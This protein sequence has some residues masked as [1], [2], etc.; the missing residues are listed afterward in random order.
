M[1][2]L[3]NMIYECWKLCICISLTFN[4]CVFSQE[5]Q[6][7]SKTVNETKQS[8][9]VLNQHVVP[10]PIVHDTLVFCI[11]HQLMKWICPFSLRNIN[12]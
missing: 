11:H 4:T 5:I 3:L 12:Y 2:L 9:F 8:S 6:K 7:Y 10:M 1:V